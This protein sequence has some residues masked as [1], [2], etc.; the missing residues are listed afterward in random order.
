MNVSGWRP[1]G[2]I[3]WQILKKNFVVKNLSNPDGEIK[4]CNLVGH[5]STTLDLLG[6]D[7]SVE[8]PRV[9]D[10]IAFLNSGSYGFTSSP[11]LFLGHETPVELLANG[12][13]IKIIRNRKKL[14]DLN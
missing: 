5:L 10:A 3:F 6:R 13:E 1:A 9:G 4:V 2:G 8:S 7:T 11:L 12:D 14:T